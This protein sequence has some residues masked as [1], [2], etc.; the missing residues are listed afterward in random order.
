[1]FL[2][3]HRTFDDLLKSRMSCLFL[4]NASIVTNFFHRI[5][6]CFNFLSEREDA[7]DLVSSQLFCQFLDSH[8]IWDVKYGHEVVN[9]LIELSS[10]SQ[11]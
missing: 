9:Y 10:K 11:M 1:M 7:I 8:G 6:F 5:S 3:Y 4:N 2:N